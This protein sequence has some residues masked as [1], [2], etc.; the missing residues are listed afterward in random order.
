MAV[1]G[2]KAMVHSTRAAAALELHVM[3]GLTACGAQ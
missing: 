2:R 1:H 3:T